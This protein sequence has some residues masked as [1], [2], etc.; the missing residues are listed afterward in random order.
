MEILITDY[1]KDMLVDATEVRPVVCPGEVNPDQVEITW[2]SRNGAMTSTL[3]ITFPAFL[4]AYEAYKS[5]G[6]VPDFTS[7]NILGVKE[8]ARKGNKSLLGPSFNRG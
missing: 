3:D 6:R 4:R 2:N 8:F 7:G 1:G 5:S